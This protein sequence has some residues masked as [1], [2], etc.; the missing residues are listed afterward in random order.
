MEASIRDLDHAIEGTHSALYEIINGSPEGYVAMFS[1]E[2]DVTLGN[3]FGPFARGRREV[4]ETLEDAATRY[5]AGQIAGFD[6][7]A[8][9]A[10]KDLACI[11]EL[12]RF[13]AKLG[14][15]EDLATIGLR[16][17]SIF[18]PEGGEWKLVHRHADPITTPRSTDSILSG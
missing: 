18:R 12:E 6:L 15:S 8:R 13:T 3:P 10:T 17:T 1:A 14:G 2:D 9:H 4:V 5:R 11:V 16:V 7:V